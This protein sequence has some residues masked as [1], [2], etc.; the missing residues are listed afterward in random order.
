M[1]RGAAKVA[2]E[3][4]GRHEMKTVAWVLTVLLIATGSALAQNRFIPDFKVI[5]ACAGDVAR[6]CSDI[7]P[8]GGRIKACIK[9]NMSKLSAGCMDTMLEAMAAARENPDTR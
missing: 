9:D 5:R 2:V 1:R 7:E 3:A 8:G 4:R 6:L